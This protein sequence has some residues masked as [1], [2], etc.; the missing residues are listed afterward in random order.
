MKKVKI[1]KAKD[2]GLKP[3]V[4]ADFIQDKETESTMKKT[5]TASNKKVSK[6]QL[7]SLANALDLAYDEKQISFTKKILTAYLER[8][9]R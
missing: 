2:V 7:K 4:P 5:G 6:K 8:E 3:F 1:V 9:E